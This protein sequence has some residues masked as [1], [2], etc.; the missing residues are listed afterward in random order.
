[1]ERP[2]TLPEG[3]AARFTTTAPGSGHT[4]HPACARSGALTAL[5][6]TDPTRKVALVLALRESLLA[7]V[8]ALDP[9]AA[10]LPPAAST[11]PGR[12]VRPE[13][14]PAQQMP[15]RNASHPQGR[16][17]LIHAI[18][19]IEFNAINLALDAA[20]RFA[21]LPEDYYSDWLCVAAEEAEHFTLLR[22]HLR[23]IGHD[24]GDFAAHNGLWD[25]AE[26]T[27]ADLLARM[28]LV[29]RTLE[30]R[31]LDV[32][33]GIRAKL[34]AAGDARGAAILDRILVDEIGHVAIG[35]RW[36]HWA[37]KR[38]GRNPI[39]AYDELGT[40]FGAPRMKPPF[41]RAARLEAGFSAAEL[42]RLDAPVGQQQ[43]P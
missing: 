5:M 26:K 20:W 8:L 4:A 19:H 29:P 3:A 12:P 17:T 2:Y 27:A 18:T 9:A 11:L 6:E 24:Y 30:A 14:M 21:H 43:T 28:A 15:R 36:Y 13:L 7:G 35:N 31:G 22:E 10:I 32:N 41:N 34:A 37:C 16:A 25:M 23:C 1:M 40:E 38:A 39:T 42:D 33:P